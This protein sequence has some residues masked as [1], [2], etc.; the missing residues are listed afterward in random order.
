MSIMM[1][2][3]DTNLHNYVNMQISILAFSHVFYCFYSYVFYYF[4]CL[5]FKIHLWLKCNNQ[6]NN[7]ETI[8][9]TITYSNCTGFGVC[10]A[11][12]K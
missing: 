8:Q 11:S 4:H 12:Y 9:I 1:K 7:K 3:Y 2:E 10:I 6:T 5:I